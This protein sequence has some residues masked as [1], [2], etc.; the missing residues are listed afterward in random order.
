MVYRQGVCGWRLDPAVKPYRGYS[1][2]DPPPEP[3]PFTLEPVNSEAGR[4]EL[5]ALGVPVRVLGDTQ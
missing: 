2:L 1:V 4:R 3:E 5:S